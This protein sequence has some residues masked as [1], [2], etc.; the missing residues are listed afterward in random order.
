VS[1]NK[2]KREPHWSCADADFPAGRG[3]SR[4]ADP[5]LLRQTPI[6]EDGNQAPSRKTAIAGLGNQD[7]G[8]KSAAA[9]VADLNFPWKTT[10]LE[11]GKPNFL[12]KTQSAEPLKSGF[13][14]KIAHGSKGSETS[15]REPSSLTCFLLFKA[16]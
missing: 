15:V 3:I 5:D 10:L 12:Q 7:S 8:W 16:P 2:C 4:V 9:E 13:P 1:G 11:V 14:G 6:D